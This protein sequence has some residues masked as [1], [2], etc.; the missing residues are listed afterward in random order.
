MDAILGGRRDEVDCEVED[1]CM[2][3]WLG[4]RGGGHW[5]HCWVGERSGLLGGRGLYVLLARYER[6]WAM[7]ALLGSTTDALL[8]GR[9]K[10]TTRWK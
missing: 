8:G 4:R 10:W 6:R 5:M 7:D 2:C 3:C 9:E 1:G